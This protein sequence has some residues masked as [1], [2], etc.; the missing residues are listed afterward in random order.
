VLVDDLDDAR[1][2]VIHLPNR[3]HRCEHSTQAVMLRR[4]GGQQRPRRIVCIDP[5][6]FRGQATD[7]SRSTVGESL[8]IG[9]RGLYVCIA[10]HEVCRFP[11]CRKGG[12]HC[13]R[14]PD[15]TK[16]GGRF[17]AVAHQ[18]RRDRSRLAHDHHLT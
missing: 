17:D 11:E 12:V 9:E 6:F 13:S 5:V 15:F 2:Q 4:V 18:V 3:E 8:V 14:L 7:S 16:A 1:F 10:C